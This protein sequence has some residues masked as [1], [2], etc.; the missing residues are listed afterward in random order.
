MSEVAIYL[1]ESK[2]K[3]I[4]G[5]ENVDIVSMLGS[6]TDPRIIEEVILPIR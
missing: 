4:L 3:T 1:I 2:L 5:S 6:V